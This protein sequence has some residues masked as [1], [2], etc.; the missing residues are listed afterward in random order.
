VDGIS[1]CGLTV[2]STAHSGPFTCDVYVTPGT[3]GGNDTNPSAWRLVGTGHGVGS[4]TGTASMYVDVALLRPFYLA[5]GDYGFAVYLTGAGCWLVTTTGSTSPIANADLSLYP[6]PVITSGIV[7]YGLFGGNF[8]NLQMWNGKLHYG[9][10]STNGDPGYGFFG[11][12]CAGSGG[13]ASLVAAPG[14]APRLGQTFRAVAANLPLSAAIMLTG[15]SNTASAFGPLPLNMAPFG[16]PGCMSRVS[17]DATEFLVG[18][19]NTANWNLAIPNNVT[20]MCQRFFN[21]ALVLD[22][23][24]NALGAV[25]SDATA[26]IVGN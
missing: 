5:P 8:I 12:G 2:S 14:S 3:F 6:G 15:L 20:L 10:C 1:I 17:A 23:G 13:I 24:A 18:T 26:G 11:P 25:V 21:Q 19:G 4:G 16:A 22:P 9:R 7:R